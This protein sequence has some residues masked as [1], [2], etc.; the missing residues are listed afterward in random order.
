MIYAISYF[1]SPGNSVKSPFNGEPTNLYQ[2]LLETINLKSIDKTFLA[3]K[4]ILEKTLE[5][6]NTIEDV[7]L[8]AS[9]SAIKEAIKPKYPPGT[10]D[11]SEIVESVEH[12]WNAA[13][14]RSVNPDAGSL[15]HLSRQGVQVGLYLGKPTDALMPLNNTKSNQYANQYAK[16]VNYPPAS[17]G[18]SG[19]IKHF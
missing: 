6:I 12:A 1:S 10:A 7:K 2:I 13:V 3:K 19:T 18:A 11:Y 14:Q 16:K 9:K 15:G 8:R 4:L 5:F 17:W